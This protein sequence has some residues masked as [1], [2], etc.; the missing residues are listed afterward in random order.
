MAN[1]NGEVILK[2]LAKVGEPMTLENI[3]MYIS[4]RARVGF[5]S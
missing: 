2:V 3:V 1:Q 5:F 4:A